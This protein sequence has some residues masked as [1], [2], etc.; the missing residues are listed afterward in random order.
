VSDR[1]S[2]PGGARGTRIRLYPQL[3]VLEAYREPE[4]VWLARPPGTIAPGP[5]DE[6]MYVADAVGK[7]RPYEYPYL[8]P[9]TGP[10]YPPALPGRDGHFDELEIGS[11]EF[12]AAH[13][14]GTVR[15]VLDV[16]EAY[17][18]QA[19]PWH[20]RWLY[21]RLELVPYVEWENAHAGF[22]FLETGYGQDARGERLYHCLNFDVLAHEL[23][24]LMLYSFMG[25]P[26]RGAETSEFFGFHESA[27]DT[28]ALVSVLQFRLVLDH[29]LRQTRGNLFHLS[30]LSRIG[31]LSQTEQIRVA[32]NAL[33]M[34]DVPGAATPA[35]VLCQPGRHA[36]AQPLTGAVFDIL[37]DVFQQR[38]VGAGIIGPELDRLSG[39]PGGVVVDDPRVDAGFAV[40]YRGRHEAF[41]VALCE[42]RD[43]VGACLAL[44]WRRLS[45]DGLRYVDVGN[46]LLA[47]DWDLSGGRYYDTI[48][49][50]LVWREIGVTPRHGRRVRSA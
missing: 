24:H 9:Y 30:E 48:R 34:S 8:P 40:A 13:M 4:T 7:P 14:Y 11:P 49:D 15:L 23:G 18:G 29:V 12:R 38:L 27:A 46:A 32:D 10:T 19:I 39:R 1:R 44:A 43:Y 36:L 42:A 50:N 31:E 35:D 37:V 3:P 47:A 25:S 5:A 2:A 22:G 41:R 17:C 21:P 26:V 6:R 20:F 28:V 45:P 33:R 16:W